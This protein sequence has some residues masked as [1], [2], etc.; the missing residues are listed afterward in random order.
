[1]LEL[2]PT[3]APTS[4]IIAQWPPRYLNAKTL[5]EMHEFGMDDDDIAYYLR[6]GYM[7]QTEPTPTPT[8]T[9]VPYP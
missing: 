6:N 8:P 5:R 7:R 1:V 9:T 2:T 4:E 3:P